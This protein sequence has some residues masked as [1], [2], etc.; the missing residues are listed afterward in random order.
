MTRVQR[1]PAQVLGFSGRFSTSVKNHALLFGIE[2]RG[3]RGASDETIYVNGARA[4]LVGAGGR[5]RT[6][7]GFVQ[8]FVRVGN[9]LVVAGS[10]RFDAWENSRGLDLDAHIGKRAGYHIDFPRPQRKCA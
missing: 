8:D 9:R 10:V 4:S 5:E 1:V 7:S 6:L 3:V 2:T